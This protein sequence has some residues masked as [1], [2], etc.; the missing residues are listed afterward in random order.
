MF[1]Q[2]SGYSGDNESALAPDPKGRRRGASSA[3]L[4]ELMMAVSLN[5]IT[6][7]IP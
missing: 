4:H 6:V 7:V 3:G 1:F 5:S 2:C